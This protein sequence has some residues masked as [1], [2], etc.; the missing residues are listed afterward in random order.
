[1]INEGGKTRSESGNGLDMKCPHRLTVWRTL[2]AL[3]GA[4]S[5]HSGDEVWIYVIPECSRFAPS[6]PIFVLCSLAYHDLN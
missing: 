2:V 6:A 3:F 5:E 4:G 1:M